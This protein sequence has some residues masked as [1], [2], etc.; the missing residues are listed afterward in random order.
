MYKNVA[1][2]KYLLIA[3]KKCK[4]KRE[5]RI[6]IRQQ[7]QYVKRDLKYIN[8]LLEKH[9]LAKSVLKKRD[10]KLLQVISELYRQ[11]V[12]MYK[13]REHKILDRIVSIYQP[14]VRPMPRG[15]DRISTEFGRKQLV[16]LKDGYTHVAL[17]GWDN[18]NKGPLTERKP[19]K[20]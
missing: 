3:K 8:T 15:K 17:I 11:Q 20:V 1:R 14:H 19:G 18:Y 2:K 4:S 6:G 10:W 12:E 13:K 7:L 16:M 9:P 5:I